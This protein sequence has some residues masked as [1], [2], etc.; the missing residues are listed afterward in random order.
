MY[1]RIKQQD[2]EQRN[3]IYMQDDLYQVLLVY[4]SSWHR[5]NH[6][7][8]PEEIWSE[9]L[10]VIHTIAISPVRELTARTLYDQLVDHFREFVDERGEKIP[11]RSEDEANSTA[12]TVL[13]TVTYMLNS[14]TLSLKE[15]PYYAIAEELVHT[16]QNHSDLLYNLDEISREEERYEK[17]KGHEL[18]LRD[19]IVE[20]LEESTSIQ[21]KSD[22]TKYIPLKEAKVLAVLMMVAKSGEAQMPSVIKYI[23]ALQRIG[24][25]DKNCFDDVDAFISA[26]VEQFPYLN[27]NKSNVNK[28]I[29][30]GQNARFNDT[31]KKYNESIENIASYLKLILS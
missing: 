20:S 30:N 29:E 17:G 8:S 18:P 14:G 2:K 26:C 19:Y 31:E 22:F 21:A 15:H 3:F 24:L 7:L 1:E 4:L 25:F 5:K 13:L 16:L 28:Q 9:A 10:R 12:A 6:D 11:L 23:K 27:F